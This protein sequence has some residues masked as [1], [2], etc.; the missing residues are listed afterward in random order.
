M[1]GPDNLDPATVFVELALQT[2]PRNDELSP[3]IH[4]SERWPEPEDVDAIW[5]TVDLE[6]HMQDLDDLNLLLFVATEILES[7]ATV[8]GRAQ[9][10]I[11]PRCLS[12]PYMEISASYD[13]TQATAFRQVKWW[14]EEVK[15]GQCRLD[16]AVLF[17]PR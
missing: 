12:I 8:D 1:L 7:R 6:E 16:R 3:W 15:A 14:C 13:V 4:M 17:G 5:L 10:Y 11:R 2:V 9:H